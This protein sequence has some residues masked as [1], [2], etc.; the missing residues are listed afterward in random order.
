LAFAA[1]IFVVLWLLQIVFLQS[2]YKG[3]KTNE[4]ARLA[5]TIVA[6]YGTDTFET[7]LDRI[8]FQNSILV[9]MTD[10][11]GTLIYSSDEHGSGGPGGF[12]GNSPRFEQ[13]PGGLQGQAQS[14]GGETQGTASVGQQLYARPLPLEFP[15]FLE[16][17]TQSPDGVVS[18]TVAMGTNGGETL[19]YGRLL[20]ETALY[21]SSPLEAVGLTTSIIRTQL[22]YATILALV[23]SLGIAFLLA[24]R[25]ARPIAALSGQAAQLA[26]GDFSVTFDK[27][28]CTELDNLALTLDHTT[29]ELRKTE[30]LRRELIANVSHDLRTP[31]TMIKAYAEKIGDISGSSPPKRAEDLAVI[32]READRLASLVDD[33]LDLSVLQAGVGELRFENLSLSDRITALLAA[34]TALAE[35]EGIAM[36]ASIEPDQYVFGDVKRLDQTLY[37]LLGNALQHVGADGVIEVVLKDLGGST[38]FEVSDHG[39]GIAAEDLPYIWDRYY[40]AKGNSGTGGSD[41][42]S[43]D[44][45]AGGSLGASQKVGTGLGLS[46]AKG[47]LEAHNARYGASSVEGEG[48]TFWFELKK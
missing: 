14:G 24:R 39:R 9:S 16:Q 48:S 25:F 4:I 7:T 29:A 26:Q 1:L 40:Q 19:V 44:S 3:M 11:E 17:L 18:Y 46:I 31:L 8:T 5:D 34:T 43:N 23:L 6:E 22:I 32:I 35:R 13:T 20:G 10:L 42:G 28:F 36:H 45:G 47:I 33:L 38:R 21:I 41:S 30:S 37:N 27:G 12:G 15:Q 2:F